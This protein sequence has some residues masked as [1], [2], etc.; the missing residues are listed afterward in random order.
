MVGFSVS[1]ENNV[2][3]ER[4]MTQ[5]K[6]PLDQLLILCTVDLWG[7]RAALGLEDV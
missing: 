1:A 5:E 4:L 3:K 7:R 6:S 2:I